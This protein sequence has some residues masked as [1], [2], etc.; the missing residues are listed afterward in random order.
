MCV[1]LDDILLTGA[2]E[3]EHLQNLDKVLSRLKTAGMQLKYDKCT[4]L[5]PAVEYLDHKISAQGLQP[6]SDKVQA[7]RNAPAPTEVPQ[8]K[9]LF[10][11]SKLLL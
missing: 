7:I 11:L 1:Y 10:G 9:I 6:T 5:L 8:L 4:F 3:Q 2:N